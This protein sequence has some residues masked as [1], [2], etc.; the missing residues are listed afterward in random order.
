MQLFLERARAVAPDF[1]VYRGQRQA[2]A[3]LCRMLDGQPL[4]LEL[5]AARTRVLPPEDMVARTGRLL[6]LL[7]GGSRDLP[8]RQRSMRAALD[9]SVQLLDPAEAGVFAQLSVFVGGWTVA[10]AEAGLRGA[11]RTSSTC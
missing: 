9:G 10:A 2:V 8:D 7:T 1:A 11:A 3:E 5:A 4:A 6:Q